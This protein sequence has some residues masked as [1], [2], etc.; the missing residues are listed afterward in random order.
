MIITFIKF[1]DLHDRGILIDFDLGFGVDCEG[2]VPSQGL[3]RLHPRSLSS[4]F[5]TLGHILELSVTV[6][7]A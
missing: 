5:K 4:S 2:R 7:R 3:R 1:E 6:T